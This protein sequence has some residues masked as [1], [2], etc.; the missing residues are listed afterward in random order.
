MRKELFG[1]EE[2]RTSEDH[3]GGAHGGVVY[4]HGCLG[5]QVGCFAYIQD[6]VEVSSWG[7]VWY[8]WFQAFVPDS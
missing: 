4:H 2:L 6:T 5:F 3:V 8:V 7:T 1:P